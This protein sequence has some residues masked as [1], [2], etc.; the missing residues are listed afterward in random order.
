MQSPSQTVFI[1]YARRDEDLARALK[2]RLHDASIVSFM[3]TS[4]IRA[5]D[6]WRDKVVRALDSSS[7]VVVVCTKNSVTSHEVTAEWAYAAGRGLSVIPVVYEAGLELPA[8]LDAFDRLDFV[9]PVYRQWDRLASRVLEIQADSPV[10]QSVIR[11]LGIEHIFMGRHGLINRFSVL[12]ILAKTVNDS[13]LLVVGRSLEAWAREFR[14]IYASCERKNLRVRMALVDPALPAADW[15]I[16]T[17]YAAVDLSASIEK[18]KRMPVLSG[19]CQGT[20]DLY[21]LPNSP[22]LSFICYQD[23]IGKC[24][25]FDISAN[26]PFDDRCAFILRAGSRDSDGLLGSMLSVC[27]DMLNTREP[28]FSLGR[29]RPMLT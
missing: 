19:E 23:T 14:E 21:F 17:D 28:A 12:Q 10:T 7:L 1:S 27:N 6:D 26:L 9:D 20:F 11:S 16:P 29:E 22:L 2:D 13:E 18:F 5:G 3:D 24:G 8:G 15:M 25:V 4:R